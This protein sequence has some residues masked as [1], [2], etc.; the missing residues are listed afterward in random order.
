MRI[1]ASVILFAAGVAAAPADPA[2]HRPLTSSTIGSGPSPDPSQGIL[3]P[4][5]YDTD[6][7]DLHNLNPQK[8]LKVYYEEGGQGTH[9][10]FVTFTDLKHPTVVLE[11]SGYITNVTCTGATIHVDFSDKSALAYAI[12]AWES[13]ISEGI[14]FVTNCASCSYGYPAERGW[15]LVSSLRKQDS[16]TISCDFT[17]VLAVDV[18]KT[19]EVTF[20]QINEVT[21]PAASKSTNTV[22]SKATSNA[23]EST[24]LKGR[25]SCNADNC[26]VA[27]QRGSSTAI[28]FCSTF[29]ATTHTATTALGP[30]SSQCAN[31][32][33]HI[34]SACSC[35]VTMVSSSLS[36]STTLSKSSTTKAGSTSK[37][38]SSTSPK[39]F[40]STS[41]QQSVTTS[42]SSTSSP[43]SSTSSN[44]LSLSKTTSSLKISTSSQTGSPTSTSTLGDFDTELDNALGYLDPNSPNF[45]GQLLPGVPASEIPTFGSPSRRLHRRGWDLASIANGLTMVCKFHRIRDKLFVKRVIRMGRVTQVESVIRLSS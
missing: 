8:D 35:L 41:T 38:T 15:L 20:G 12:T 18:T 9:A 27:I 13:A 22:N 42:K 24:Y 28:S 17:E 4:G 43:K 7:T 44:T 39:S 29:L 6:L 23:V 3:A 30:Y 14:I 11:H 40:V 34:S 10:A 36:S 33:S 2:H 16:S 21:K 31:L 32:P 26:L 1:L 5:I 25:G 45:W 19:I 37:S